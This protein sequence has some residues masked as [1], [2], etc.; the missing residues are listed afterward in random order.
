M[1][2]LHL[3]GIVFPIQS[4]VV[5]LPPFQQDFKTLLIRSRNIILQLGNISQW[6]L[7]NRL[8]HIRCPLAWTAWTLVLVTILLTETFEREFTNNRTKGVD[9]LLS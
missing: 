2:S 8:L 4:Q 5:I 7:L 3:H 9:G 6:S 1:V